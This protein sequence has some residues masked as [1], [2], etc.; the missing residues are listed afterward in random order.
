MI[1]FTILT[2]WGVFGINTLNKFL[3]K[4][5]HKKSKLKL[6]TSF[7]VIKCIKWHKKNEKKKHILK[8][9]YAVWHP[10]AGR[11]LRKTFLYFLAL[12]K[13]YF[14]VKKFDFDQR[15]TCGAPVCWSKYTKHALYWLHFIMLL[16][17]NFGKKIFI[18]NSR[19]TTW[20]KLKTYLSKN[21]ESSYKCTTCGLG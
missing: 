2:F 7:S 16:S 21:T 10:K 15:T 14:I 11:L 19:L 12:V 20:D 5:Y 13:S 9:V 18:F 1:F 8:G 6:F 3:C 17:W 4:K